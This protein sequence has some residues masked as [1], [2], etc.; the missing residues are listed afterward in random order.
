MPQYRI[1]TSSTIH[2]TEFPPRSYHFLLCSRY[3][4]VRP[5]LRALPQT[6]RC[7]L[8]CKEPDRTISQNQTS[9]D[10][11]QDPFTMPKIKVNLTVEFEAANTSTQEIDETFDYSLTFHPPCKLI[12]KTVTEIDGV[13]VGGSQ[14]AP[15]PSQERSKY[16]HLE[17]LWSGSN[18]R[19]HINKSYRLAHP[20]CQDDR[21]RDRDR[22]RIV[23]GYRPSSPS[24]SESHC[25]PLSSFQ[26][27]DNSY[28]PA[29]SAAQ[30]HPDSEQA[31]NA[32][33]TTYLPTASQT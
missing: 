15:T 21:D 19:D 11:A 18:H 3:V 10:L 13:L 24:R 20:D 26:G 16:P 12:T 23:D 22:D 6:S 27:G 5:H 14:T 31:I 32:P 29:D 30:M 4:Q 33:N 2:K 9:P 28:S 17:L 1:F 8:V 7:N 25:P